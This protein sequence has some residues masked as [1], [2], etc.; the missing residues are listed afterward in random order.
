[1]TIGPQ[2]KA[3]I[4]DISDYTRL[5]TLDICKNDGTEI[6]KVLS[7]L[8]YEISDKNKLLGEAK[9]ERLKDAI[10]DFF[11]DSESNPDDTLLFYYSG[12]GVP[13][14]D[15]D[16]YIASS[17]IDPNEPYRRGFSFEELTKMI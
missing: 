17:D 1:M 12:H 7:S 15:G 5:Q 14:V 2:R 11:S 3:L 16:I 9:G 13:D 8:G 6:Y 10:Y 4:V